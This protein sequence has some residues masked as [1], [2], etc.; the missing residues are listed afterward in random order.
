MNRERWESI[1]GK[2]FVDELYN[3]LSFIKEYMDDNGCGVEFEKPKVSRKQNPQITLS[4]NLDEY[5]AGKTELDFVQFYVPI[6][7]LA[8]ADLQNGLMM[9]VKCS[10]RVWER[11][12]DVLL[13]KLVIVC[14]RTLIVELHVKKNQGLLEGKDTKEEYR[15][16]ID[17]YVRSETWH[18]EV[19]EKYPVLERSIEEVA[20]NCVQLF[21]EALSRLEK[22]KEQIGKMFC[23]GSRTLVVSDIKGS[24]SDSH[25][26]GK[27]ALKMVLNGKYH[28]IYKPHSIINEGI[29][30]AIL[31]KLAGKI[32][33]EM[34][35]PSILLRKGYGWEEIIEYGE[36]TKKEQA[37]RYYYRLGLQ[38][39]LLFVLGTND[40]HGENL[41]ASKEYPVVVDLE[42]LVGMPK[43]KKRGDA[44]EMTLEFLQSSVLSLGV[45]PDSENNLNAIGIA[46]ER[47]AEFSVPKVVNRGTSDIQIRYG[48]PT[49][50]FGENVPSLNGEYITPIDYLHEMQAGFRDIY[51]WAMEHKEE[52][53]GIVKTVRHLKSRYLLADTQRY[54]VLQNSSYH[55]MLL[56]N[57]ADRKVYMHTIY[58]GRNMKDPVVRQTAASEIRDLLQHDIPLF[59]FEN[60]GRSLY[61]SRGKEFPMYFKREPFERVVRKIAGLNE[62]GL[63]RQLRLME[64]AMKLQDGDNDSLHNDSLEL[65][66]NIFGREEASLSSVLSET[67]ERIG[68]MLITSAVR[69]EEGRTTGWYGAKVA[70]RRGYKW[71]IQPADYYLYDGM[72]GMLLFFHMLSSYKNAEY[73]KITEQIERQLTGYTDAAAEDFSMAL[74]KNTGIYNGESSIAYTYLLLYDD[75]GEKKYLEYAERHSGIVERCLLEE[76]EC[77]LLDGMSGA[78]CLYSKL[79]KLTRN[80][81]YLELA[82]RFG[83]I[84]LS[85]GVKTENGLCWTNKEGMQPLLGMAH[86]NSGMIVMLAELYKNTGKRE[87]YT[88]AKEAVRYEDAFYSEKT[89]NWLDFRGEEISEME[90]SDPVAWCHGAGGICLSRLALMECAKE[91]RDKL[92]QEK[93]LRDVKRAVKKLASQGY[94]KGMCLCHGSS[95]NLLILKEYLK[96]FKD[97]ETEKICQKMQMQICSFVWEN[98]MLQEKY[99]CGIM[100]GYAGIGIMALQ[101]YGNISGNILSLGL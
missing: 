68:K 35:S 16:F 49:I 99:N 33:T 63:D 15:F 24:I 67:A 91:R 9:S 83:N 41:I 12:L 8:L 59:T 5:M 44:F 17:R 31:K 23:E 74:S 25:S 2:E 20:G 97:E 27:S 11:F 94:R 90:E 64:M 88:A 48:S 7:R 28:I 55:P 82:E 34:K 52:L 56:G 85:R 43:E 40:I 86:G 81:K 18:R 60:S 10:E 32:D 65:K 76:K 47:Q 58:Y 26:G 101:P 93:I 19:F 75:T 38:M 62:D 80:N 87:Y 77:D 78:V 30:H 70:A 21:K 13:D 95:G 51:R 89:G 4:Y 69:D 73:Q 54:V 66:E 1:M 46:E 14:I 79:Y 36:C 71:N 29:Y 37:E 96:Y 84:I 98:L 72:A 100:S 57:G 22:D 3:N 42:N 6:L 61:D 45:L 53:A 50:T 39:F 92:F